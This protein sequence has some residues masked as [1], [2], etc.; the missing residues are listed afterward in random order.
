MDS[1]NS[2]ESCLPVPQKNDTYRIIG[3][4]RRCCLGTELIQFHSALAILPWDDLKN[5]IN[6]NHP[7]AIHPILQIFQI[8]NS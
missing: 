7:G 1:P 2:L 4:G 6:S 5:R 8:L 3:K